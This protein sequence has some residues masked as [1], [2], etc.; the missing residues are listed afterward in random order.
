VISQPRREW[1]LGT[2]VSVEDYLRVRSRRPV[3]YCFNRGRANPPTIAAPKPVKK[4]LRRRDH[5]SHRRVFSVPSRSGPH[6]LRLGHERRRRFGRFNE[7][8]LEAARGVV[9]TKRRNEFTVQ[10]IVRML[11]ND[12]PE[13]TE[14]AIRASVIAWCRPAGEFERVGNGPYRL[15]VD[16][17]ARHSVLG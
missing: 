13:F 14:S 16:S 2:S 11:R 12:Y 1:I 17:G 9:R 8:I 6:D 15:L 4:L 3:E 10:E 7:R 5:S